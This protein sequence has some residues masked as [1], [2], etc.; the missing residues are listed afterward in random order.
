MDTTSIYD[1]NVLAQYPEANIIEWYFLPKAQTTVP[2]DSTL[3]I[4][5]GYGRPQFPSIRFRNPQVL[6]EYRYKELL[7]IYDRSNDGQ[8][9]LCRQALQ[10]NISGD[11]EVYRLVLQEDTLPSHRFP[12][13]L[14]VHKNDSVVRRSFKINNR[15]HLLEDC[16]NESIYQY[17]LRFHYAPNVDVVKIQKDL[18]DFIR[19]L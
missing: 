3:T 14:E 11:G 2:D 10:E 8:R 4:D 5:I 13:S 16:I 12:C 18:N 7:Y 19:G 6:E 9:T 15:L 17:Y 1:L